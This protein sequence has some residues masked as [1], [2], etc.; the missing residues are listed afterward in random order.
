MNH[1][2]ALF[3]D[4]FGKPISPQIKAKHSLISFLLK[5]NGYKKVGDL[6]IASIQLYQS[7]N[8]KYI[9]VKNL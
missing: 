2:D 4:F 6:G 3:Q 9:A 1:A 8:G 5:I 7:P